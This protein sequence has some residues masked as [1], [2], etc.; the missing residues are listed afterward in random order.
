M[1]SGNGEV[2]EEQSVK[3]QAAPGGAE[4][5]EAVKKLSAQLDDYRKQLLYL[6]ADFEN[7]RKRVERDKIEFRATANEGLILDLLDAYENLERALDAAKKC[8]AQSDRIAK[9]LEM[10][11]GQMKAVLGKY[12]LKPIEAAGKPFDPRVMEAVMQEVSADAEEDTVLEEFQRGYTLSSKVIR[13]SKVK[14]SRK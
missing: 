9:G 14:V 6:Q 2:D 12:G 7:Y 10:V 13:C 5:G 4:A 11:Y 3:D 8:D 1:V